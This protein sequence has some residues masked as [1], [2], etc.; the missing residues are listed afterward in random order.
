MKITL[1]QVKSAWNGRRLS[2]LSIH[3]ILEYLKQT[4]KMIASVSDDKLLKK[5]IRD[6]LVVGCRNGQFKTKPRSRYY[7]LKKQMPVP[8]LK[9]LP[10]AAKKDGLSTN[11]N[12]IGRA[13][14]LAVM[15][16]LTLHD[17]HISSMEV[18]EGIDIVAMK[19]N[20]LYFVQ[21]KTTFLNQNHEADTSINEAPFNKNLQNYIRYIFVVRCGIN[22]WRFFTF[23]QD[24]IEILS[25]DNVIKKSKGKFD[26][27][28]WFNP[29]D[30]KP[31]LK[32]RNAQKDILEYMNKFD[33]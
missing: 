25:S 17:Y 31:Y 12:F 9:N 28:I 3:D 8:G 1:E 22:D 14:E 19:N 20:I 30:K 6:I 13:G 4:D 26:F 32:T 16:E 23:S 5:E 33:L 11:T 24:A 18:D 2:A 10:E 21:V 7:K 29:E 15:A 27:K